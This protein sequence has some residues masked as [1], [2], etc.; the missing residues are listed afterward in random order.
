MSGLIEACQRL[1][2]HR[3]LKPKYDEYGLL[4]LEYVDR[5]FCETKNTDAE[6]ALALR[7]KLDSICK[8]ENILQCH[9]ASGIDIHPATSLRPVR[10]SF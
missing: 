3:I 6:A 9:L 10:G 5:N 7:E 8:G 1:S 4:N 2:Y